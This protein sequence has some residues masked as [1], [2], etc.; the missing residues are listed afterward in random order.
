MNHFRN[1]L[2][3]TKAIAGRRNGGTKQRQ[4]SLE[5]L[6]DRTLMA[7]SLTA[8]LNVAD[9]VL[10]VEGTYGDDRIH[11]RHSD[12]A[13]RVDGIT[14]SMINGAT[15]TSVTAI[16]RSLV[17][18]IEVAA[19]DGND[20]VQMHDNPWFFEAPVPIVIHGGRGND[21][22]IGGKGSDTIFGE[23]GVD[24]ILGGNGNDIIY[25][26]ANPAAAKV[27]QDYEL[28]VANLFFNFLGKNEKW[29]G[30]QMSSYE[31]AK[32]FYITPDGGLYQYSVSADGQ[33][34]IIDTFV[35]QMDTSYYQDIRK[36][37]TERG[38]YPADLY[39][40]WGA[41][42]EKWFHIGGDPT[43]DNESFITP[44]GE[45][46]RWDGSYDLPSSGTLI[47]TLDSASFADPY[48]FAT[49]AT[50]D[51]ANDIL[52]GQDGDDYLDGGA[53]NDL[54]TGLDGTDTLVG[55][56][57]NDTMAGNLGSDWLDGGDGQD[58][59]SGESGNDLL[60]AL[61]DGAGNDTLVGGPGIDT[62]KGGYGHDSLTGGDGGDSLLGGEGND[63][64]A[65]ENDNDVIYGGG[66]ND[67]LIGCFN[68]W[69]GELGNANDTIYGG[70]GN[71]SLY[72]GDGADLLRGEAN[73]NLYYGEDGRDTL[74]G[75]AGKDTMI[76]GP[77]DDWLD[78]GGGNDELY[79]EDGT[80]LIDGGNGRDT[81]VGGN[82][83]DFLD[84]AQDADLICG[85]Q[86]D[87]AGET[88]NAND[89]LYG[90]GGNDT[91][92]GGIG[93]DLL[94]GGNDKDDLWGEAGNDL[95]KGAQWFSP[96]ESGNADDNLDGGPGSDTLWGGVGHDTLIGGD[97]N[98][99]LNGEAGNDILTGAFL[100]NT[101]ETGNPNDTLFGNAGRDFLYG[102]IG[103]DYL[104]GDSE[105]DL[106]SGEEGR[107]IMH[108][109]SEFDTLFADRGDETLSGGEY[110]GIAVPNG[111]SAAGTNFCGP[112]GASRFLRAY[113]HWD[114]TYAEVK[115]RTQE[116]QLFDPIN[117]LYAL[118]S[119]LELGTVPDHMV[120]VMRQWRPETQQVSRTDL[121]QVLR[122]LGEGRPVIA[123]INSSGKMQANGRINDDGYLNTFG[124]IVPNFSIVP[125]TL[126][127]I[128]LTG[129]NEAT[130]K[131]SYMDYDGN[132]KE[133]S[134]TQFLARWDYRTKGPV[135]D[136][137]TGPLGCKERTIIW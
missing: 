76:A 118:Q 136:F 12:G 9:G 85:A 23:S 125:K 43:T 84:G 99:E 49:A 51:G 111:D 30:P 17:S 28:R 38:L 96:N 40:G 129:F 58:R 124:G 39:Y 121:N 137:L 88:G 93:D 77:G 132:S 103:D 27:V 94:V 127:W 2:F 123:L 114:A 128:V 75:V 54:L 104:S 122:L 15:T 53:G 97:D 59:L 108:G 46:Y 35:E 24:S 92:F 68:G 7:A 95:I 115:S 20:V 105:N 47:A 120:N 66:G 133:M 86:I 71:D 31:E 135:G 90:S 64:I 36:L 56:F 109:G 69:H 78:G 70:M 83:N 117:D 72:G 57:G 107:D 55:S 61:L 13:V 134:Y 102:G 119:L 32:E 44:A 34:T 18:K 87:W 6:S 14:I 25:G 60:D 62:L 89:S 26:D 45:L 73:N 16:P 91:L 106:L 126:H 74:I 130:R 37:E 81:L 112:N 8:S 67:L 116:F 110:V 63:S 19:L 52:N 100:A 50:D 3:A 79:G 22:L 33:Y 10:R 131:I 80:D 42:G 21:T 101:Q 11:V 48:E 41:R 4:L 113:Q 5:T 1:K 29:L 65:G 82:D 98:D